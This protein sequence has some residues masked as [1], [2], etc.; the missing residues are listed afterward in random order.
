MEWEPQD[1][2]SHESWVNE[3][4]VSCQNAKVQKN[5]K[6]RILSSTVLMLSIGAIGEVANLVT[7]GHMTP[8]Q[9]G[10]MEA[11]S[12]SQQNSP[13]SHNPHLVAFH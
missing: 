4:S 6:R 11:T 3:W 8:V 1:S 7:S 9:N 13:P 5:L 2:L 10:I 12:T